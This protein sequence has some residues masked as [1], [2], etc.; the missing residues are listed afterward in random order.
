MSNSGN[1]YFSIESC[2]SK[3]SWRIRLTILLL[4][5]FSF[6]NTFF[7]PYQFLF[8]HYGIQS[9]NGCPLL[10]LTG[11]PCPMCGMGRSLESIIHFHIGESFYYNPSGLFFLLF[12]GLAMVFVFVLSLQNK[13]IR[14][15]KSARAL[16]YIPLILLIIIW[17]LN[18]LYGHH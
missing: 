13:T 9:S 14:F 5:V 3:E 7:N 15:T 16:W 17:V 18:I 8:D 1:K 11:V 2:S 12:S 4:L 6:L 10:T